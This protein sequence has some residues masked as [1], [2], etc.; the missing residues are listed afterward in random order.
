MHLGHDR[1]A[2]QLGPP[3]QVI[4]GEAG[5]KLGP[6]LPRFECPEV[7]EPVMSRPGCLRPKS[8]LRLKHP[9][10]VETP[11]ARTN[12]C[13]AQRLR[14]LKLD[15]SELAPSHDSLKCSHHVPTSE[16]AHD[17]APQHCLFRTMS[18][19]EPSGT[20]HLSKK[21][22]KDF[23]SRAC[24]TGHVYDSIGGSAE[25]PKP[26]ALRPRHNIGMVQALQHLRLP[27]DVLQ[28]QPSNPTLLNARQKHPHQITLW[29]YSSI[30]CVSSGRFHALASRNGVSTLSTIFTASSRPV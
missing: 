6:L 21:T 22:P 27:F 23:T 13:P 29:L 10:H 16:L 2:T 12:K 3:S 1:R 25:A 17:D 26:R 24:C 15:R 20:K 7:H 11:V 14:R 19:A 4:V 5:S 30:D 28:P 8:V 9:T 18:L